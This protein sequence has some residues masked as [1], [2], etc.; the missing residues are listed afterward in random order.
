LSWPNILGYETVDFSL[1]PLYLPGVTP[2]A[3]VAILTIF[4]HQMPGGKVRAAWV[5]SVKRLGRAG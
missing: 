3:L 5:D 4:L 2:F 1:Q